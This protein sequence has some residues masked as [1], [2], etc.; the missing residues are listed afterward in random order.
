MRW[1]LSVLTHSDVFFILCTVRIVLVFTVWVKRMPFVWVCWIKL[2]SLTPIGFKINRLKPCRKWDKWMLL[3]G[4]LREFV[5]THAPQFF[6]KNLK[7]FKLVF[8]KNKKAAFWVFCRQTHV[9]YIST[10]KRPSEHQHLYF[11]NF[12]FRCFSWTCRQ[13][14]LSR[15]IV[16]TKKA[17]FCAWALTVFVLFPPF[18]YGSRFLFNFVHFR[19]VFLLMFLCIVTILKFF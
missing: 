9:S 2:N 13:S 14:S 11:E 4:V 1:S 15:V 8:T 10:S 5:I 12:E 16:K 3:D 7:H 19:T 18:W 6:E 17:V